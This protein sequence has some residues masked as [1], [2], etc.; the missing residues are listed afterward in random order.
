LHVELWQQ[1]AEHE[2]ASQT[3]CPA[4]LGP[5]FCPEAQGAHAAPPVPQE[6]LDWDAN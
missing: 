3:H 4:V 5:Q 1:P 6:V 2:L